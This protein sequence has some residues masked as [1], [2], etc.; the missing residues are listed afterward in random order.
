MSRRA[1]VLVSREAGLALSTKEDGLVPLPKAFAEDL[2]GVCS[3]CERRME[4]A[5]AMVFA[6]GTAI[7][8]CDACATR[9][10]EVLANA[11]VEVAGAPPT[12][13]SS[14]ERRDLEAVLADLR[15]V[16]T[17]EEGGYAA[18]VHAMEEKARARLEG[19]PVE[20]RPHAPSPRT[21]RCGICDEAPGDQ[22]MV[23]APTFHVCDRCI[24]EA[25]RALGVTA[26]ST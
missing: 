20:A 21:L 18:T 17:S 23:S 25:F 6:V 14:A 7:R 19:R 9:G 5:R 26:R 15:Q 12:P 16:A 10:A 8:F 22:R 1:Y 3:A 24:G 4:D 11:G 2:G 13:P